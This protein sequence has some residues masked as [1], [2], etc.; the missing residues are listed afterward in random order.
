MTSQSYVVKTYLLSVLRDNRYISSARV[1]LQASFAMNTLNNQQG[2]QP[3][4]QPPDYLIC[5]ISLQIMKDPVLAA[6][7][8]TCK[9]AGEPEPG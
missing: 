9:P 5:P 7:G 4:V 2:D 1:G 8:Q 3:D 6:D